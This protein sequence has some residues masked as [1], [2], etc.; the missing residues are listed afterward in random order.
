M[1]NFSI[2][3]WAIG[4]VKPAEFII[5]SKCPYFSSICFANVSEVE[6]TDSYFEGLP[7]PINALA[8]VGIIFF[9]QDNPQ[10]SDPKLL[11]PIIIAI[12]FLM[13]S[14]IKYEK[15]PILNF[16][17]GFKNSFKIII[18]FIFI[19]FFV[20]AY[21]YNEDSW[22]LMVFVS[23]YILSGILMHVLFQNKKIKTIRETQ[24]R[25]KST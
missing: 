8:I 15:F 9:V 11:L 1:S 21:F 25:Q 12:S 16:D 13:V 3:L 2:S 19:L 4:F 23:F 7:T 22:I 6:K 10:Y 14:K 18:L 20:I 5:I 24:W 17:S